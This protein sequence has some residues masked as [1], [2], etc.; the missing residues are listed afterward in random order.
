MAIGNQVRTVSHQ[1]NGSAI[2]TP[3]KWLWR[4]GD[5]E[6]WQDNIESRSNFGNG[7]IR[8]FVGIPGRSATSFDILHDACIHFCRVTQG[9]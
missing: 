6:L 4:R 5:V 2:A 1:H 9:K 3:G 7:H 8:Y